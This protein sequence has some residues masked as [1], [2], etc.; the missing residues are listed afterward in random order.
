MKN[1]NPFTVFNRYKIG[2]CNYT[3][4][5]TIT[6]ARL[7]VRN[8][9]PSKNERRAMFQLAKLSGIANSLDLVLSARIYL[10]AEDI[11]ATENI[12]ELIHLQRQLNDIIQQL[13]FDTPSLCWNNY[14]AD[15]LKDLC[16]IR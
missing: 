7:I 5:R 4:D 13:F 2:Y 3:I 15:R 1:I 12:F 16:Y 11:C 6:D 14:H 9:T 10:H 8:F